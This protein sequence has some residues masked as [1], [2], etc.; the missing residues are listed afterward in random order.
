VTVENPLHEAH[1]QIEQLEEKPESRLKAVVIVAILVV[2]MLT[3]AAGV[4]SAIWSAHY[5][6]TQRERQQAATT[7]LQESVG[8]NA[9]LRAVDALKDDIKEATWR[10]TFLHVY[11]LEL[12][13]HAM[14]TVL[15]KQ[16][17]SSGAVAKQLGERLPAGANKDNYADV[18]SEPALADSQ[19]A[20]A[21][22]KESSGWLEKQNG[23]LAVVSILALS[24]FLLGLAL[25]IG[26]RATQ[27]GFTVLAIV[28][29]VVGGVRLL[30]VQL[31]DITAPTEHCIHVAS[32]ANADLVVNQYKDAAAKLRD[33]VAECP[34]Y[35][36]AWS[37]LANTYF[38]QGVASYN[39][40][41]A[42]TTWAQAEE[43][44][45]RALDAA[46]VKTGV[47]YNDLAFMQILNHDYTAATQNLA[48]AH[49][50]SPESHYVLGTLAELAIAQGDEKT[51]DEYLKDAALT[52]K[53]AGPYFRDQYFFTS[54]RYD[55][56][57]FATAGITGQKVTDF[58]AKAREYE[59][60]LDVKNMAHPLDT[61]GASVS[62]LVFRKSDS[63]LGRTAGFITIG[64]SYHG[65]QPGD[66]VSLRF[67]SYG[68]TYY[69]PT[70]SL[71]VTSTSSNGLVGDGT[72]QPDSDYRLKLSYKYE[73]TM[74]VYLNGV[75]QGQLTYTP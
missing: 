5:S 10:K 29:T 7:S 54:L 26:N 73:T 1:E 30:Q 47:L 50:L 59:A 24:L 19:L 9:Q 65:L 14:N 6:E 57:Y 44:D 22:A 69:D 2:T 17:D 72:E 62:N 12:S 56:G 4:L 25:T 31:T 64:Y 71:T 11:T 66:V 18:L 45:Q 13:D 63:V 36:N 61:H 3:T 27:L 35:G 51:A 43:A 60:M 28:M 49:E 37:Q 58:F 38:Y 32:G 68:D 40:K 20:S 23:A 55:N 42:H 33:V 15:Q 75:F 8:V 52:L 48:K 21:Y 34:D 16:A 70:A 41:I 46:D 39:K 53:D 67:Y 74:E